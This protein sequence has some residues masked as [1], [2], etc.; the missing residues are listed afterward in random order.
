MQELQLS[1]NVP[2]YMT[3]ISLPSGNCEEYHYQV[4]LLLS[5]PSLCH[6]CGDHEAQAPVITT[7][8][9]YV[10]DHSKSHFMPIHCLHALCAIR[11]SGSGAKCSAKK[12]WS[13]SRSHICASISCHICT[14]V[15]MPTLYQNPKYQKTSCGSSDQT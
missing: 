6:A 15:E 4:W 1:G 12:I 5:P 7:D 8:L 3:F 11:Q 13:P 9:Q 14:F 10:L 2:S